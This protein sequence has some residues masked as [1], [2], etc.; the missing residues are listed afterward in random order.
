MC[1]GF[2][3]KHP[4]SNAPSNGPAPLV[5]VRAAMAF[6]QEVPMETRR[7]GERYFSTGA[8]RQLRTVTPG[9]EYLA[10]VQGAQMYDVSLYEENG[11]WF[12]DCT[13]PVGQ[14]CKHGVAATLTLLKDHRLLKVTA[15]VHIPLP[16]APT[17]DDAL[18]AAL[19]RPLKK[20]ERAFTQ[21]I[22]ELHNRLRYQQVVSWWDLQQLFP[23][24]N[25]T[26]Y[27]ALDLWDRAP[28]DVVEFWRLLAY[29]LEEQGL[30]V[31]AFMKSLADRERITLLVTAH[32]RQKEIARWQGELRER[33]QSDTTGPAFA[34]PLDARLVV[35]GRTL[36][37]EF[38]LGDAA[39][40]QLAKPAKLKQLAEAFQTGTLTVVPAAAAL[41]Q[42]IALRWVY[43]RHAGL[44]L[45]EPD[46]RQLLRAWLSQPE[47]AGRILT[48]D[49]QPFTRLTEPLRWDL[50]PAPSA[51]EDYRL[52][53]VTPAGQ[54]APPILTV[55]EGLPPL[56]LTNNTIQP[57]PP[58]WKEA[59]KIAAELK[60]PAPAMEARDGIEFLTGLGMELPPR[61]QQRTRRVSL[62]VTFRCALKPSHPG[63][64]T[65]TLFLDATA[66][67]RDGEHAEHY[68]IGGWLLQNPKLSPPPR[69]GVIEIFDRA[70]LQPV[71]TLLSPLGLRWDSYAQQW[72]LRLS[73]KFP[74]TFAHWL[75]TIPPGYEV[76]L[77]P[78][79]A[80]FR[81]APIVGQVRLEC[82]P[83]GVDWFD[84]KVVLDVADTKLTAVETKLLL[85][86]RG[87]WVRLDKHGWRRLQFNI[88]AEQD[89]SL[90]RLGLSAQD[91]TSAPQRLH[92]LQ[93]AD[94]A[95]TQLLPAAQVADIRRRADALQT[96]VTPPVPSQ[97]RAELRPYQV[98]G[99]HFLAYLSTNRFGGILADD[100]GLGK[101]VQTLTWL[102]WLRAQPE[103]AGRPILVVCPKSV[104][105]NWQAEATRFAP[106][107]R[108]RVG[109][110]PTADLCVINY[111]QLRSWTE[112]AIKVPWLAVILD[113]GQYIKNPDSQTA[114]AAR[115]L[116]AD[117]RLVLTGT[118]I[119]NRLLDL[120][121]LLSFAM[122]GVLGSRAEFQRRFDQAEDPLARRRL[123]ARVRPFLLR[124]TKAQ[125]ATDLP[126]RVEEDLL[127]EMEG[128]QK[129]LYRA[130]FKHAQQMLLKITSRAEFDSQRFNFLT[131]LLRLRQICCH[132]ALVSPEQADTESAK[133]NALLD[134]LEPLMEEG[135]KVLVFSQFV[136]MLDLLR[137][138]LA[139][140][141]WPL[142]SLTGDT[143][144]RGEL[145]Q[146]FQNAPGAAVF[147][148]SLKAGGFGLNL[149]A[150]SYVVL[151][152]PW[153]NPAVENQAIDRTHRIGQVNKV[154]AYR[155]LIKDSIEEKIRALQRTKRAIADDVL[156]EESFT[157]S[158]SLDDLRFLFAEENAP[159]A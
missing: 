109:I 120:W 156:G 73:K 35:K 50:K 6:L 151:F 45:H 77:A 24:R 17:L 62:V 1:A 124:R 54:P 76:L 141:L 8:V 61:L 64:A 59:G 155:L 27:T 60:I 135:H 96:R 84:L 103:H 142:F 31:P 126:D 19:E 128:R 18:A 132:P 56:Y 89:E 107:L 66:A 130:A 133:V 157:K 121:S 25:P 2:A 33:V 115:A 158:L 63:A 108:V 74:D 90:A 97:I 118:P 55:L 122:P 153:W 125:V 116:P 113:E 131:A 143:E 37:I 127:C 101:T 152:D 154:M 10:H 91:F 51:S 80:S 159:P 147:L 13:C 148:I 20:E 104:M 34:G 26:H 117:Y 12:T 144:N 48:T 87:G 29:G 100:M 140:R 149:T 92:A 85:D 5:D 79:L 137:P 22:Q 44:D 95:A 58:P 99:Y 39:D 94:D 83:A 43:G 93:L 70:A 52:R 65:E 139:E 145:V 9:I 49:H 119:E 53:L 136:S 150:A 134:L 72:Y 4:V 82:D 67:T 36:L 78:A 7:R 21:R 68:T 3:Y 88:T 15:P 146:Q 47:L 11:E 98:E 138:Q 106:D 57:G 81:E 123:A 41:W 46:V 32:R 14:D 71:P 40:F 16:P 23:N 42:S 102:T 75:A 129:Q 112:A 114:Q 30:P 28:A 69:D 38:K 111:T 105:D 110:E 86:A